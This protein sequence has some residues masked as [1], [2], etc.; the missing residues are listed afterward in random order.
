MLRLPPFDKIGATPTPDFVNADPTNSVAGSIVN[1][2]I[3]NQVQH[4]GENLELLAG[5]TPDGTN[6]TQW[7]QAVSRGGIW[8]PPMTG[9]GDLAIATLGA[10]MPALLAGMRVAGIAT[11]ANTVTNPRLRLV[12]LGTISGYT[13]FPILK[14]DGSALAVGDIIPGRRYRYEADGAGNVMISGG[15]IGGAA[16]TISTRLIRSGRYVEWRTPGTYQWIVPGDAPNIGREVWAG[17]GSGGGSYGSGA[18][19]AGGG[20][21][22]YDTDDVAATPGTVITIVVGGGGA[23]VASTSSGGG[24]GLTGGTTSITAATSTGAPLSATGGSGGGAGFGGI[25]GTIAQGG[26]GSTNR[27]R[28]GGYGGTGTQIPNGTPLSGI[29]GDAQGTSIAGANQGTSG[30]PGGYPAGGGAGASA[31]AGAAGGAGGNGRARI[32]Y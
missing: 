2:L 3:F 29:G 12:N 30:T 11:A 4:E 14:E 32:Y 8:V 27:S 31:S 23:P 25:Q 20:G 17:G 18:A 24:N 6:L 19:G 13:D 15:G 10:V 5:L 26:T 21:G 22:G 7:A 16:A 28:P 1:G 9:T